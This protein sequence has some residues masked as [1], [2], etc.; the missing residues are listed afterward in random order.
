LRL[1]ISAG[2]YK[3]GGAGWA[4]VVFKGTNASLF[5]LSLLRECHPEAT[6]KDAHRLAVNEPEQ[7]QLAMARVVPGFFD[8]LLAEMELPPDSREKIKAAMELAT[9]ALSQVS[10]RS[11]GAAK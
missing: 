11:P 6:E 2:E 9:A 8:L 10:P 1:A 4:S 5:L 7:V 3:T